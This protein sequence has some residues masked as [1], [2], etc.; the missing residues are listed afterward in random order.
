MHTM[1]S[2]LVRLVQE[3]VITEET[4]L[5]R[6]NDVKGILRDLG[7]TGTGATRHAAH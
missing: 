3:K 1:N 6:S 7:R 5:A 2:S 4:A